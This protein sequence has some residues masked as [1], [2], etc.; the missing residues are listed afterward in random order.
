MNDGFKQRLV[1]ALVLLSLAVIIWPIVF[2]ETTG[3]GMDRSTQIPPMPAFTKFKVEQPQRPKGIVP[4]AE[5]VI[6]VAEEDRAKPSVGTASPSATSPAGR[7][8]A[9]AKPANPVAA[10]KP[11]VEP[12]PKPKPKPAAAPVAATST[13]KP[14]LDSRG[15]PLSWSL[16]VASLQDAKKAS[17]LKAS[18]IDQGYKAYLRKVQTTRGEVSR[19]YIGPK[20]DRSS[21]QDIK[22]GVDKRYQVNSLIVQFDK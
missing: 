20:L 5:P 22:A 2:V 19:V 4:V 15:L 12:M 18:L 9:A 14:T 6:E 1:G 21:L 13:A 8:G 7:P 3:P 16:Q 11:K 10:A 17:E